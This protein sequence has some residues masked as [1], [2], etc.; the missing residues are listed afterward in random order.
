[1]KKLL[2][3]LPLLFSCAA[4][5]AP[6]NH[7]ATPTTPVVAP[8]PAA[9]TITMPAE[10]T[11]PVPESLIKDTLAFFGKQPLSAVLPIFQ[12]WVRFLNTKH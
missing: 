11:I 9:P 6:V 7:P 12:E 1:M 4:Y 8:P 10:K 5:A 2:F 3:I